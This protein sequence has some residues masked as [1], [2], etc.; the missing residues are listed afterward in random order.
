M[1][2]LARDSGAAPGGALGGQ[3]GGWVGLFSLESV[4]VAFCS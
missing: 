3:Q 2:P 4:M 1:F